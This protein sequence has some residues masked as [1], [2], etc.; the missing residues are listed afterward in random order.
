[1]GNKLGKAVRADQCTVDSSRGRYA[2][3]CVEVDLKKP[4]VPQ[5]LLNDDIQRVEYEGLHL[6]CF[7]CGEYGHRME[8]CPKQRLMENTHRRRRRLQNQIRRRPWRFSQTR[9]RK[10]GRNKGLSDLGCYLPTDVARG[11]SHVVSLRIRDHKI[12]NT[13]KGH[14]YKPRKAL[15]G[16]QGAR[17]EMRAHGWEIRRIAA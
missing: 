2:R 16:G 11:I 4:L 14:V 10:S 7:E 17:S 15:W 9:I 5:F 8:L 12:A 6:I 1:M 13:Q 3:V